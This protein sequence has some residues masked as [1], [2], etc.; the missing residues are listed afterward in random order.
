MLMYLSFDSRLRLTWPSES[1]S[2]ASSWHLCWASLFLASRWSTNDTAEV[3]V[4]KPAATNVTVWAK[5]SSSLIGF[6]SA[7]VDERQMS[8]KS[9]R[10][11]ESTLFWR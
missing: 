7:S 11:P 4:P 3:V 10:S 8:K 5:I 6:P 1:S 2:T 9:R